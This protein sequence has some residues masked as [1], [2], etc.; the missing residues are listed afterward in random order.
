MDTTLLN[1]LDGLCSGRVFVGLVRETSTLAVATSLCPRP[2]D[3]HT[4][5]SELELL[6]SDETNPIQSR[7]IEC[8]DRIYEVRVMR[9]RDRI[10]ACLNESRRSTP[11]SLFLRL[12]ARETEVLEHLVQGLSN[13]QTAAALY[14]SPRTIEKHRASIHR[15]M[16]THS[17]A[18]LTRMWLDQLQP[19]ESAAG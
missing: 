3:L 8:E 18:I 10:I 11:V 4:F 9:V 12:S 19:P 1:V 15:K 14:L 7:T 16:G 2:C 13:K 17:L 6:L 5:I